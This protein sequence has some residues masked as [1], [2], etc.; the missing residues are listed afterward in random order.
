MQR[1]RMPGLLSFYG[2]PIAHYCAIGYN[3]YK[4]A[5]FPCY[6]RITD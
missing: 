1:S 3:A 5:T 4:V 2:T 6:E